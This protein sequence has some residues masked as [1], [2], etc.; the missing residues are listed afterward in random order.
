MNSKEPTDNPVH[1]VLPMFA[2]A[3]IAVTCWRIIPGLERL[4]RT[5]SILK[6]VPVISESA[7]LLRT[8]CPPP[9]PS[10]P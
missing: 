7:A 2:A 6:D 8:I 1:S 5:F 3:S 9:S 4:P 10:D